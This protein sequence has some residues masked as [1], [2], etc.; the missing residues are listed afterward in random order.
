[1][2]DPRQAR[3]YSGPLDE[4]SPRTRHTPHRSP[5]SAASRSPPASASRVR[6]YETT[7]RME[8][9]GGGFAASPP[10]IEEHMRLQELV[11]RMRAAASAA[12]GGHLEMLK[13]LHDKGCPWDKW[14]TTSA[15]AGG[16]LAVLKWLRDKGCS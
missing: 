4:A 5:P 6:G 16:H 3:D 15:A 12:A 8:R 14:A 7:P 1:M 11:R 9:I 13:W 10:T 2:T